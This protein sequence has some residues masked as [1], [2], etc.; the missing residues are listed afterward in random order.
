MIIISLG[1]VKLSKL[2]IEQITDIFTIRLVSLTNDFAK[3]VSE[4]Y[5][6]ID[7]V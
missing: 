7:R 6:S 4:K 1:I 5:I 2:Y 3:N